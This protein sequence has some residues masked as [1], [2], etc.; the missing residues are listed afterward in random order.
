MIR[1]TKPRIRGFALALI[2][3]AA[4]A[5]DGLAG[6]ARPA[7]SLTNAT[8]G[9]SRSVAATNLAA[10]VAEIAR[11]AAISRAKKE[12]R[13]STAV[14]VAVV[15]AT[16]YKSNP[17]EV[18]GT[19]LELTEA[20][21]RAAPAFAEVIA[22]AVSFAP[23]LSR[24]DAAPGQIR[25]AAFAAA[26]APKASRKAN[27]AAARPDETSP[28]SAEDMPG[29][30]TRTRVA[31]SSAR[32]E[33]AAAQTPDHAADAA[34]PDQRSMAPN[35]T[36][37]EN[38]KVSVTAELSVRRDDNVYLTS[39]NK[40]RDSIV[41]AT[42]GVEFRFG[43]SS[44]AHGSLGYKTA[45]TRYLDH[46]SPNVALGTGAADFG[47]DNG[48]LTVSGNASFQQ[49]NQNNS[50]VAALGQQ[51]IYRRD[52]LG[53]AT[54][55]E[56]HL[57]AKT[58][59]KT[60]ATY[61]KSTYKSSGL[62][63]SR[64]TEV[65][66]KFYFETTPKVSLST[67]AAYRWV[68]PQNGGTSGRDLAYNVGARGSF[69]PKLS[70]EFSVD[71]RTRDVGSNAREKLWGFD[72]SLNYE[73]TPKT[74]SALIFSRDFSA[75]ALGESLKNSNYAFRLS[76]DLSPQWQLGTGL[77][78]RQVAYG[79]PVFS[80]NNIPPPI[81]RNDHY[82]DANL[83]ATYLFRSWLSATADYNIRHNNS[84]LPGAQFSNSILSLMLGWRY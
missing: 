15:A 75:G 37:G 7:G 57:T 67:G 73:L 55:V 40:V 39:A 9:E 5:E 52:V 60:G 47:Y 25:A 20:A 12:K 23:P 58:S 76:T 69:T 30:V 80:L 35:I 54:N 27:V 72:G 53:L 24:I 11:S 43:Q 48:S 3:F 4:A 49:L 10:E 22:G 34:G 21:A 59:V 38:T 33:P 71:Y 36:R 1:D 65:P 62:S 46:S 56:S 26:K 64:E 51:A 44:L 8:E 14:R 13:I 6:T 32:D 63:G 83:Q 84:N 17:E 66:L 61:S 78:Y 45:F 82:W 18:L 28:P 2:F 29:A 79:P 42:P 50:D 77:N 68:N 81:S 16:A 31:R 41:A 70:G 19:A 74:T